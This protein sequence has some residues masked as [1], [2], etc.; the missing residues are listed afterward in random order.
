MAYVAYNEAGVIIYHVLLHANVPTHM[1]VK[2]CMPLIAHIKRWFCAFAVAHVSS[3]SD[4]V[5][6]TGHGLYIFSKSH[7]N[8]V[9]IIT[10]HF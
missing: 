7:A 10:I 3:D 5:I 9:T 2:L 1:Q 8:M 4:F 6:W